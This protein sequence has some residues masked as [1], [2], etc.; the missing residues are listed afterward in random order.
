MKR[1]NNGHLPVVI[2]I[3]PELGT[4]ERIRFVCT[5]GAKRAIWDYPGT[6]V[7]TDESGAYLLRWPAE[8]T[9]EFSATAPVRLD[10]KIWLEGVWDN[11]DTEP[12]EFALGKTLL[13][14]EEA[15]PYA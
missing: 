5:Q 1:L 14:K 11:P 7:T 4:V 10:T 2:E 9:G 13:T 8:L 3:P 12:V 15:L 6:D